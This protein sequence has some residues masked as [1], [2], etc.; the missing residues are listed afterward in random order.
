MLKELL[1]FLL[2]V[3]IGSIAG[4]LII[5]FSLNGFKSGN[6]FDLD[7]WI[8]PFIA[9]SIGGAIAIVLKNIGKDDDNL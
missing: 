8:I 6:L 1:I 9:T 2:I 5:G 3:G 7:D 4:I